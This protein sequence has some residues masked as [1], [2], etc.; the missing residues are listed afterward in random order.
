MRMIEHRRGKVNP[1]D[2]KALG[3]S[4]ANSG[5]HEVAQHFAGLANAAFP[6]HE[7]V[8]HGDDFAFHAGDFGNVDDLAVAVAQTR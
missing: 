7:N 4:R 2:R 1:G 5:G 6:E 3:K 8:L